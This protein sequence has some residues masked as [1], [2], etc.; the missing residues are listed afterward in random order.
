MLQ[1]A[2]TYF[3]RLFAATDIGEDDHLLRLVEKRVIN[4]MNENLLKLFIE[5]EITCAVKSMSSL[6]ALGVDGFPA[7]F[8]L[9]GLFNVAS[10]SQTEKPYAGCAYWK[11]KIVGQSSIFCR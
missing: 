6:K 1:L 5:E 3:E 8:Y 4:S 7:I 9:R 2:S 11:R 10:G